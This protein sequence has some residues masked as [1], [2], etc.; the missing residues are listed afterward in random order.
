MLPRLVLP[1]LVFVSLNT[2]AR[3]PVAGVFDQFGG[4]GGSERSGQGGGTIGFGPAIEDF[5]GGRE[6]RAGPGG[7]D[8]SPE[9]MGGEVQPRTSLVGDTAA[10]GPIAPSMTQLL[11]RISVD[12]VEQVRRTTHPAVARTNILSR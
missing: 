1:R 10:L 12:L 7:Q 6:G 8:R 9:M 2:C 5:T 11:P 3:S 4:L